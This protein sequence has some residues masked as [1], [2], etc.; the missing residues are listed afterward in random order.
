MFN[1]SLPPITALIGQQHR[2]RLAGLVLLL[3]HLSLLLEPHS[4]ARYVLL[5]IQVLVYLAW[6]GFNH[7]TLRF[8]RSYALL[9][10][11]VAGMIIWLPGEGAM[12]GWMLLL[13]G[14]IAGDG[15]TG[16]SERLAQS[17]GISYLILSSMLLVGPSIFE[18]TS[19][20]DG[21]LIIVQQALLVLP[22]GMLVCKGNTRN[23]PTHLN[24]LPSMFAVVVVLAMFA[25]IALAERGLGF[26]YWQALSLST[27]IVLGC[28]LVANRL[29]RKPEGYSVWE[30]ITN[31]H[32]LSLGTSAENY[33]LRV[34][35]KD[36]QDL[37]ADEFLNHA[38]QALYDLPWVAG[39]GWHSEDQD[40]MIGARTPFAI[41][42][43]DARSKISIYSHHR[44]DKEVKRH[45]QLLP[46]LIEQLY[47]ARQ[48]AQL[49][50]RKSHLQAVYETGSRLTHDIKN[51]LQS[52]QSL[53][54]VIAASDTT[55]AEQALALMQRQFPEINQRLQLTL[56]KLQQP[57]AAARE[58]LGL[59]D[60]WWQS[61]KLRYHSRPVEFSGN[62]VG[63]TRIPYEVFDNVA[64]NLLDNARFKQ[65]LDR[66]I[67]IWVQ[68]TAVGG[69]VEF[70][71]TD[72]G[73]MVP[74][75]IAKN[76]FSETV[77]SSKGLGVGLYQS[78]QLARGY[79]FQLE[80]TKNQPGL[81]QFALSGRAG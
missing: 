56:D 52:M 65:V 31:Q 78:H 22:L 7:R 48:R 42:V 75:E 58:D 12:L 47:L 27:I 39:V 34:V 21:W 11:L 26:S 38:Y 23:H 33:L 15:A 80:L 79:G 3:L 6:Q 63:D 45:A 2:Y 44:L 19:M 35:S 68:L 20:S 69:Q 51:L 17:L 70:S 60:R 77:P 41:E 8:D 66:K 10:L 50:Q 54:G 18:L 14:H 74:H 13:M 5:W 29:W 55:Q 57:D 49:L 81:V 4:L 25:T 62:I 61:L 36:F 32:L 16:M 28:A 24:F 9:T 40:R 43:S 30:I 64:E 71:V 76:L 1:I 72:S 67:N 73:K 37:T 53:N 46:R 59:A